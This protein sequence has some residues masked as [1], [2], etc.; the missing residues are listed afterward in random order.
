MAGRENDPANGPAAADQVRRGRGRQN[1]IGAGD[2]PGDAMGRRH[3]H[4]H[5][6]C[7]AVAVAAV[8]THHQGAPLHAGNHLQ[9]RFDETFEVVG[10]LKLTTALAQSRCAGLLV[11]ERLGQIH[12]CHGQGAA[13]HR[14]GAGARRGHQINPEPQPCPVIRFTPLP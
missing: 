13:C 4:D 6:D 1:S 8:A 5:S 12:G 2:H 11:A 14:H 7:L 3:P 10:G 9:Y